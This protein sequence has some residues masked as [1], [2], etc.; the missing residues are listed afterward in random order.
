M[1]STRLRR[2]I[3]VSVTGLIAALLPT[4]G[5]TSPAH[6]TPE[7]LTEVHGGTILTPTGCD[8]ETPP[9]TAV[10]GVTPTPTSQGYV[11]SKTVTFA[12]AGNHD[13]LDADP[14]IYECQFYNT[15]SAPAEW[16]PCTSP[17][18]YT[19]LAE[20]AGVPYTFR[21]RGIDGADVAI[22]ACDQNVDINQCLTDPDVEDKD[23]SPAVKT[24]K[25]DTKAPNTFITREPVDDLTPDWPVTTTASPVLTLNTSEGGTIRCTLNGKAYPCKEGNTTLRNLSGGNKVFTAQAVDYA[26][27]PDP[28]KSVTRFYVPSNISKGGKS[29]R[30]GKSG[31]RRV[32]GIGYFGNDYLT[33]NKVGA[34]LKIKG[35][36][37]VRE[38]RLFAPAGPGYGK[39]Q[40]RVG[41]GQW[42]TVNL[43]A[44]R[45]TRQVM[46]LVRDE[47]SQQ[48]TGNLEIRVK[49]LP[50]GG[51]VSDDA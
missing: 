26:G 47:Y 16:D 34:T 46:Y 35:M 2:G 43:H 14:I 18:V 11:R 1:S 8:D 32:P 3:A 21:V 51:S 38:V 40:V 30:A 12:F 23:Q 44:K 6:A 19:D 28:T 50:K 36:R 27:N 48:Q 29:N 45:S 9:D 17:V 42:Y 13:D 20:Y 15:A 7:C 33:A 41:R 4:V 5:L 22:Q 25:V 49:S 31:W 10:T 39:L 24:V 37:G